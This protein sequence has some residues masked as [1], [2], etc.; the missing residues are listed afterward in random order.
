M[1]NFQGLWCVGIYIFLFFF[2]WGIFCFQHGLK[3]SVFSS[4]W[5]T[6]DNFVHYVINI[7]GVFHSLSWFTD[8]FRQ[9]QRWSHKN[10]L[11][12]LC[13]LLPSD[14]IREFWPFVVRNQ[15]YAYLNYV[16]CSKP[17]FIHH[18]VIGLVIWYFMKT[19]I[20][21]QAHQQNLL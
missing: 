18:P 7:S 16:L 15:L 6:Q 3:H 13:L 17:S 5:N 9:W 8:W 10:E 12:I 11:Y 1:S 4:N 20:G 14:F 2:S 19:G 21:V